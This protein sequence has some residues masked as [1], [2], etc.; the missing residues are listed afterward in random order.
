MCP[1]GQ[2]RQFCIRVPDKSTH[3]LRGWCMTGCGECCVPQHRFWIFTKAIISCFKETSFSFL[4]LFFIYSAIMAWVAMPQE[5]ILPASYTITLQA[6]WWAQV[7]LTF[8][9][10]WASDWSQMGLN[11]F[12]HYCCFFKAKELCKSDPTNLLG[13]WLPG[14]HY[15]FGNPTQHLCNGQ[16]SFR[17]LFSFIMS[18]WPQTKAPLQLAAV[19]WLTRR[20]FSLFFSFP[21]P[22][23]DL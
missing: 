6:V 13:I 18:G 8:S 20:E 9:I 2:L 19:H 5:F 17:N 4:L 10:F 7:N 22:D 15:G 14:S 16:C 3:S 21:G 23:W 1:K 12:E 11:I